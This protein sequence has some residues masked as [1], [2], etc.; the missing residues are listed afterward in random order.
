MQSYNF[1][2]E[3]VPITLHY[4]FKSK[5]PQTN[6]RGI[7]LSAPHSFIYPHSIIRTATIQPRKDNVCTASIT[8]TAS[9]TS[10]TGSARNVATVAAPGLT[11]FTIVNTDTCKV[12]FSSD[13]MSFNENAGTHK[14]LSGSS[15]AN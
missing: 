2:V 12:Q 3:Q 1:L 5:Y 15:S 7:T 11:A 8:V 4:L 13:S 6:L 14:S 9:I 10:I